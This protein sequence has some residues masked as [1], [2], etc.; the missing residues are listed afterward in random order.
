MKHVEDNSVELPGRKRS[1]RINS[2]AFP[3]TW[4]MET[5][6]P[7]S[8]VDC[9]HIDEFKTVQSVACLSK[10]LAMYKRCAACIQKKIGVPCRFKDFRWFKVV[11]G[12]ITDEGFFG[13]VYR[14][15]VNFFKGE[16]IVMRSESLSEVILNDERTVI[17][18][19]ENEK[20]VLQRTAP[21]LKA[22]VD[23]YLEAFTNRTLHY[24]DIVPGDRVICDRCF[25]S[26]FG[27]SWCCCACG[28]DICLDCYD[29]WNDSE[30]QRSSYCTMKTY[31][32]K[33]QMFLCLVGNVKNLI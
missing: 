18:N 33:R 21:V 22:I 23:R 15:N 7:R 8:E 11:D 28:A 9:V 10:T 2:S 30:F 4:S 25:T 1:V 6:L 17:T 19:P 16:N 32:T 29:D 20:Y 14:T 13:T 24:R 26:I 27:L 31:H 3:Q 5:S 12:N